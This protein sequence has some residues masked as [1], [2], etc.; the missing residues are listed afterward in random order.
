MYLFDNCFYEKLFMR[1]VLMRSVFMINI[2]EPNF[3]VYLN[4]ILNDIELMTGEGDR[5]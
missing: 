5:I 1:N 3:T 2:T 4:I